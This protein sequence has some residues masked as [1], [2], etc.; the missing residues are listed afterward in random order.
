MS[1]T[2]DS[3]RNTWTSQFYYTD[4][5]GNKKKK[6]KRGFA[7]KR[8]ALEW[9][10]EF[11]NKQ[12]ANPDMSLESLAELYMEDMGSRLRIS[13]LQNKKRI[14]EGKILPYFKNRPINTIKA[15]DI[16]QWQNMLIDEN[17]SD[18]YLRAVNAQLVAIFNYASKYY[19]FRD[20]PCRKTELIGKD[21]SGR[22]D[23]WTKEEFECFIKNS[24]GKIH[25]KTGLEVLY[26]TGMRIGELLAL[27][28]NDIDLEAKTININKTLQRLNAEDII[29]P[30]KTPKSNRVVLIPD[31]LCEDIKNYIATLYAPEPTD[32]LFPFNRQTF[33]YE[34]KI[35][36]QKTGIKKIR[37]HDLRHSHAS[38]LIEL[39]FT[40]LLIAERLGHEKVETTLNT[41]SHLYPNKQSQVVDALQKLKL[42][43]N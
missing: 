13:T 36:C 8:E 21:R 43:P 38:L 14:I 16:R 18:T 42:E 6:K 17:Y 37:I 28:L 40:P 4:W 26:Y 22:I 33:S 31:F 11:L 12:E 15:T 34:I 20:N 19:D 2:K 1:A 9:E 10:R 29:T 30:P 7:T 23:F 3:D 25:T 41:Y 24:S 35:T 27:T 32:R 5:Q 39:G